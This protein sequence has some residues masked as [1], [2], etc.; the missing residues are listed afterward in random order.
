MGNNVNIKVNID[1][2][3]TG[4]VIVKVNNAEY[5][6]NITNKDSSN[7]LLSGAEFSICRDAA[8]TDEI[9]S[10]VTINNGTGSFVGISGNETIY[11]VQTKAPSGYRLADPV[12]LDLSNAEPNA[13]YYFSGEVVNQPILPLPFTGGSG[14]A[15]YTAI[16]L[17][18]VVGAGIFLVLYKKKNNKDEKK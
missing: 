15:I 11:L 13:S 17:L 5:S 10:G 4:L 7:N 2:D 6:L 9:A 18:I 8:C 3:A 1:D 16:G 14:T 12:A